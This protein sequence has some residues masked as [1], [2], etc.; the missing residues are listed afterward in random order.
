MFGVFFRTTIKFAALAGSFEGIAFAFQVQPAFH[1]YLKENRPVTAIILVLWL[2]FE[3]VVYDS[4][5]RTQK[6]KYIRKVKKLPG[7]RQQKN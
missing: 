2:F 7:Y 3:G 5:K 1:A 6:K 4:I